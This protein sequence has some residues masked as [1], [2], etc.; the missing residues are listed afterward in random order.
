MEQRKEKFAF[1]EGAR[2]CYSCQL[3]IGLILKY[4][5]IYLILY[6]EL[7]FRIQKKSIAKTNIIACFAFFAVVVCIVV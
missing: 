2:K 3:K 7:R 1:F 4:D 5:F 6:F